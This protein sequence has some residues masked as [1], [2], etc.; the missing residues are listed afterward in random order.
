MTRNELG[1][2]LRKYFKETIGKSISSTIL[3]KSL[4]SDTMPAEQLDKIKKLAS[5]RGHTL[6][7]ALNI[8]VIPKK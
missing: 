8:Y 7:T 3:T 5:I 2:M 4:Y 6:D 1:K